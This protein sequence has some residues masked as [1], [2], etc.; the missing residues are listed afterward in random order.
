MSGIS[1]IVYLEKRE[2]IE[3]TV[4]R[5]C[6]VQLR[7]GP[8]RGRVISNPGVCLGFSYQSF[9]SDSAAGRSNVPVINGERLTVLLDG[10]LFNG[11]ELAGMLEPAGGKSDIPP[12]QEILAR[13]WLEWGTGCAAMMKGSFA[14]VIWDRKTRTLYAARDYFGEKPFFYNLSP[15]GELTFASEIKG[16]MRNERVPR[17]IDLEAIYQFLYEKG[18][19]DPAT[20]LSKVKTLLPGEWLEYRNG[21]I[22]MGKHWDVP[23]F[24][25]KIEDETE[26]VE[27]YRKLMIRSIERQLPKDSSSPGILFSGG[28]DSTLLLG[29]IKSLTG[30]K[31]KTFTI[32]DGMAQEELLYSRKLA[33]RFDTDHTE[34]RLS[35]EKISASLSDL[36][37]SYDTP[38]VGILQAFYGSRTAGEHGV[39]VLFTGFGVEPTLEPFWFIP[40]VQ[41]I[42]KV[43]SPLRILP[44][45]VRKN[46]YDLQL[47]FLAGRG[48]RPVRSKFDRIFQILYLYSMYKRGIF[49][50]YSTG[51]DQKEIGSFFSP[52]LF[53][54]NWESPADNYR[55]L[56]KNYAGTGIHDRN[57][58]I[59]LKRGLTVNAVTKFES[60]AAMNGVLLR[61]PF[62]DQDVT[63]FALKLSYDLK[64]RKGYNKYVLR[65][66]CRKYVSDDCA[67]ISKYSFKSPMHGWI[68]GALRPVVEKVLSKESIEGRGIF[69]YPRI[70]KLVEEFW[71]GSSGLAWVDIWGFVTLELWLRYHVD[72]PPDDTARPG[73]EFLI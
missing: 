23:Y 25:D 17:D 20:P 72:R 15:G 1:G 58:M 46:L 68:T 71:K 5:M 47:R 51:F 6:D 61:F 44:E 18:F 43:L 37:L 29:M 42:E 52:G 57:C 32:I 50:W 24:P 8:D 41:P 53:S 67:E 14:F 62:L 3:E 26:A 66:N 33:T 7:R 49:R 48:S 12:D 54:E 13:A 45:K 69:D 40:R 16:L 35:P 36:I 65:E 39:K 73:N 34:I 2:G 30:K 4:R 10:E 60:A 70:K 22:V 63:E 11:K 21:R 38:G 28:T 59:M 64:Y 31:I 55:N 27:G 9:K 19:I 56:Y